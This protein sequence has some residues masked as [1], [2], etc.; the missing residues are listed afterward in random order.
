MNILYKTT[1][2]RS[3]GDD[4]AL[5]GTRSLV[6][7]VVGEHNAFIYDVGKDM[8]EKINEMLAQGKE[9]RSD[10]WHWKRK[11][12]IDLVVVAGTPVWTG[13][14]MEELEYYVLANNVPV[15]YMGVGTTSGASEKTKSVLKQCV[16]FIA[17]DDTA[18]NT[19]RKF[20]KEGKKI[21]CPSIFSLSPKSELGNRVGVV[22]QTDTDF[23]G[24]RSL[25]GR[26][27]PGQVLLIAHHIEDYEILAQEYEGYM[28]RYSRYLYDLRGFY[29]QC[30]QIYS[31]RI[32]GAHLAFGL[33]IPVVC[34]KNTVKKSEVCKTIEVKVVDPRQA[35]EDDL[36][37]SVRE[38]ATA[39]ERWKEYKE[40]M[41]Q[42]LNLN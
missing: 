10:V 33:A 8:R 20:G 41:S 27:M 40:Y 35:T 38:R 18:L 15:L 22:V 29:I 3:I 2:N 19:A 39:N 34:I 21:C 1:V 30:N 14:E 28:I 26:Y 6:T 9:I 17:R 4:M 25:I 31:A 13:P 24:Q 12:K 32:H 42:C 11:V 7:K 36:I 5:I 37:D 23:D 16:G